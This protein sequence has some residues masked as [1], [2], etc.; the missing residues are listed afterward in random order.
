MLL[1]LRFRVGAGS[2]DCHLAQVNTVSVTLEGQD[3]DIDKEV[4]VR[5]CPGN[6]TQECAL[7]NCQAM[8]PHSA[9]C[10]QIMS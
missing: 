10:V 7:A 1:L 3:F 4:V 9:L 2:L 5:E 6:V 8:K